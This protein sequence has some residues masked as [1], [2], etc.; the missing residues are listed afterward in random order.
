MGQ[1][2]EQAEQGEE[3][4]QPAGADDGELPQ[5]RRA[6]DVEEERAEVAQVLEPLAD[7]RLAGAVLAG[8]EPHRH[9]P[10]GGGG[11]QHQELEEDLET[12]RPE[13]DVLDEPAAAEEEP[14][15]RVGAPPCLPEEDAGQGGGT[16]ADQAPGR[17]L[18]PL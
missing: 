1:T 10:N 17:P 9:V 6:G 7:R 16:A 14:R 11:E 15:Q 3:D 13:F 4:A 2:V 18:Q 12:D 5:S 8:A